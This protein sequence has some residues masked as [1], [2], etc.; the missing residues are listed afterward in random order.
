MR[1]LIVDDSAV[2]R[3]HLTFLCRSIGHEPLV[4]ESGTELWKWIAVNGVERTLVLLDSVMPDLSGPELCHIIRR[5][6][7]DAA[8]YL[9]LVSADDE[10]DDLVDGLDSGADDYITKPYIATEL[11]ARLKVGLRTIRLR[12]RL[13][14]A[15]TKNL[16]AERYAAVGQLAAGAAH[17]INNPLGF[18]KSNIDFLNAQLPKTLEALKRALD[19]AESIDDVRNSYDAD[20]LI[21]DINDYSDILS[22]MCSGTSRIGNI[23]TSLQNFAK[24]LPHKKVEIDL[25]KVLNQLAPEGAR[26]ILNID[27]KHAFCADQ[28][29]LIILLKALIDNAQWAT[30]EH[31]YIE[32][33]ARNTQDVFSIEIQDTGCGIKPEDLA[34][35]MDPFFTTRP[36]GEAMGLG[37]SLA[38]GIVRSHGGEMHVV[39]NTERGTSVR[40]DFPMEFA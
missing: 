19:P 8:T 38:L 21:D 32:L 22:D 13:Q 16:S 17:E 40:C 24:Q 6:Y 14:Q 28:Y 3:L 36:V 33:I 35:V 39:S 5:D 7:P 10:T 12:E 27:P 37:L 34:H 31:G 4:F 23:I 15:T 18:L 26:V 11:I 9:I 30:R 20:Q 25:A 29:Q 1:L 2:S